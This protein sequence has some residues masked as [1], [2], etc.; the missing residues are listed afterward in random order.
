MV[1]GIAIVDKPRGMTSHDVVG[2][3]RRALRTR[4]VG[5]AGTLDPMATGVLVLGVGEGTKLLTFLT[6]VDK[7]Y[8]ATLA[9]GV[10]TDSLDA[11]GQVD[12]TA[13]VPEGVLAELE[14]LSCDG[15]PGDRLLG[16][17]ASELARTSQVPPSYSAIHVAGERA[18]A[19]ARRGEVVALPA[20]PITVRALEV[21]SA[22]LGEPPA[23]SLRVSAD[24]GYYVRSLARD[25]AQ[26]LGTVGHLT[27]LRRTRSGCFDANEALSL[28]D[29][30]AVPL[31]PLAEAARRALPTIVL[32]EPRAR[33]ARHGKR[34]APEH[35]GDLGRGPAA[36]LDLEGALVAVG[37]RTEDG[38]GKVLRGFGPR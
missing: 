16:A 32:D 27:S 6:A 26:A 28:A 34:I 31:V 15:R 36:W 20:R 5:H 21:L 19:L 4:E 2:R 30:A 38:E 33:D 22:T 25:L 10:S 14:A 29:L 23:L 37:E 1:S 11:D 13:S 3:A 8:E 17:I 18:H 24:K 9:L 12:E 7:T 35:L